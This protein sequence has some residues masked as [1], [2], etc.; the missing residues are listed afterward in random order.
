MPKAEADSESLA[1]LVINRHDHKQV[2]VTSIKQEHHAVAPLLPHELLAHMLAERSMSQADLVRATGLAK[3]TLSDL[4][5]GKRPFTV[6]QMYTVAN[7]F[8]LPGPV[9]MPKTTNV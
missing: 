4:T 2:H 3:A 1:K 8:G 5:T 7:V 6:N 9:F